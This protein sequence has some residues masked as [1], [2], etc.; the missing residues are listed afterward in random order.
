MHNEQTS[1]LLEGEPEG[2]NARQFPPGMLTNIVREA[3]KSN[4]AY[5]KQDLMKLLQERV[6]VEQLKTR[7][8][9]A[10]KLTF[11]KVSYSALPDTVHQSS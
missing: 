8:E 11:R 4:K 2:L 1:P 10:E 9:A 6:K 7:Q 5:G 3:R